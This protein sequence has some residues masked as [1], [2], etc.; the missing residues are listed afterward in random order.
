MT[1]GNCTLEIDSERGMMYVHS[2]EGFT[3]L[4]ICGM[5]PNPPIPT[6]ETLLD[7]TLK[8]QKLEDYTFNW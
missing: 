8:F 2:P 6:P 4:R 1:F 5:K 3:L 7:I